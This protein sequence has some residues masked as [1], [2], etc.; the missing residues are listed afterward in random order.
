[1]LLSF[2][3]LLSSCS[4]KDIGAWKKITYLKKFGSTDVFCNICS[5]YIFIY[6]FVFGIKHFARV[7]KKRRHKF[8]VCRWLIIL[9]FSLIIG[10]PRQK[11]MEFEITCY[12]KFGF[13]EA[14]PQHLILIRKDSR[15]EVSLPAVNCS[16]SRKC[17]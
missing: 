2:S 8:K 16:N 15:L 17:C 3:W 10:K 11:V 13:T 4:S 14:P 5:I 12:E 9:T 1:M 7:H 6:I